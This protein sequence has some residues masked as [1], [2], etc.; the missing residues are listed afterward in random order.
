MRLLKRLTASRPF[1]I[2]AGVLAADYLRLVWATNRFV[3]DPPDIYDRIDADLPAICVFWHGQHFLA[4]F[5][6][7]RYRSKVIISRHRDGEINAIAV[8]RFGIG[9]IRGSGSHDRDFHRKGGARA[10]RAMLE[11]LAQGYNIASTADVPK[12][13][14]IASMG[15]VK[16][17]AASGRPVYPVAIATSRY[18]RLDTWDGATINLPFGRGAVAWGERICVSRDAD[19]ATLQSARQDIE[20]AV[21]AVTRRA[22][23]LV[24]R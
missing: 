16:L 4:P 23:A 15:I 10:F 18:K 21:N 19:D 9:T 1:Q 3:V 13:S 2:A 5:L 17:A 8:E 12:V 24:E 6:S 11:A 7:R 22:Y 14:R 20:T